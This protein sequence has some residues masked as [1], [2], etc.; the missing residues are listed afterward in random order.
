M[1]PCRDPGRSLL[2][3]PRVAAGPGESW[4]ELWFR[5]AW[6]GRVVLGGGIL[7][8]ARLWS[9]VRAQGPESGV[10][11]L[12]QIAG[13]SRKRALPTEEVAPGAVGLLPSGLSRGLAGC[14]GSPRVHRT[15][16]TPGEPRPCVL[17][18]VDRASHKYSMRCPDSFP[19]SWGPGVFSSLPAC[20]PR[21]FSL[22]TSRIRSFFKVILFRSAFFFFWREGG[23][24]SIF[25]SGIQVILPVSFFPLAFVVGTDLAVG[26]AVGVPYC[27]IC[28]FGCD[29]KCCS[30]F[31]GPAQVVDAAFLLWLKAWLEVN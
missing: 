7:T 5:L 14:Q 17:A 18:A 22:E 13:K 25:E 19:A 29:L 23:L 4:C 16:P 6:S 28:L 26:L 11:E 27:N 21:E 8:S 24:F 2:P 10:A 30:V 1:H 9:V 12:A 3:G 15:V 20:L 31:A